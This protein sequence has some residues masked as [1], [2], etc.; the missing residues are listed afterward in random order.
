MVINIKNIVKNILPYGLVE[1][2]RFLNLQKSRENEFR[3][4]VGNDY[5]EVLNKNIIFKNKH[6]S[7]RCFILGT[8]P[9]I[10]NQNISLLKNKNCIF[11]SQFYFHKDY[12]N[13]NPKYH[14][15]SGVNLHSNIPK[16]KAIDWYKQV[17]AEIPLST[18]LFMNFLDKKFVEKNNLLKKHKVYYFAFNQDLLDVFKLGIDASKFLY[19]ASGIPILAIQIALFMGFKEI[20]LLGIDFNG[21]DH[22]YESQKSI[23][24][25]YG[26]KPVDSK[27]IAIYK[28]ESYRA[29]I[30]LL[31]QFRTIDNYAKLVNC[32]IINASNYSELDIFERIKFESLF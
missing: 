5:Q 16:D 18:V 2:Y 13:I 10:N 15:F 11:L 9:S 26:K 20:Y 7:E 32:K 22:F 31:D 24:D 12:K 21:I 25:V 27:K 30:R 17:D 19:G 8:G 1:K 3:K 23:V 6:K 28:E 29:V 4:Q 14:L